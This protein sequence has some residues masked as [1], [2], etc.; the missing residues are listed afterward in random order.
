MSGGRSTVFLP[1]PTVGCPCRRVLCRA[2]AGGLHLSGFISRAAHP[3]ILPFVGSQLLN[4]HLSYVPYH[5][6][7][8]SRLTVNMSF[9]GPCIS[10]TAAPRAKRAAS[11]QTVLTKNR[12]VFFNKRAE[13]PPSKSRGAV[14]PHLRPPD[15][16]ARGG[17][18]KMN[19][20]KPK[21]A[22][23]NAANRLLLKGVTAPARG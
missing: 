5:T 3:L 8:Y 1:L 6:L 22:A 10:G 16:R 18:R 11:G 14:C 17:A 23:C 4:S 15:G 7:S 21:T 19:E 13:P 2:G 9:R 12:A 20:L